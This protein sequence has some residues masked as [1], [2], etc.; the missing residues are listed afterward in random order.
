MNIQCDE[1][2]TQEYEPAEYR[3]SDDGD[4]ILTCEHC[5]EEAPDVGDKWGGKILDQETFS[6]L[7]IKQQVGELLWELDGFLCDTKPDETK[8][9]LNDAVDDCIVEEIMGE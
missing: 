3:I 8:S 4:L 6:K 9:L 7:Y 2:G 1:C 5:Y